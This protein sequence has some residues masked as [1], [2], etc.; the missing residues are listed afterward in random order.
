MGVGGCLSVVVVV[1]SVVKRCEFRRRSWC[2]I[3]S[4]TSC[5]SKPDSNG[6]NLDFVED[7]TR[8]VEDFIIVHDC[9]INI[10][11]P[12]FTVFL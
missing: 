7:Q 4:D 2:L 12:Y 1:D 6:D 11:F 8:A 3:M 9:V 5:P 10:S